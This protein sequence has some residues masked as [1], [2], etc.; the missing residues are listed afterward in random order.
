MQRFA[1]IIS[2]I[3][4]PLLMA[5]YGCLLL[6]FGIRHTIFDYMT[7]A[8]AKWRISVIV[9][10]FSFVFP[11]L[12]ILILYKLK[13]LPSITLSGQSDRTF[14]YIMT[15]MFYFGLFYLLKDV[16]IWQPVKLFVLGGGL[17]ILFVALINLK[18]KISAH[19]TGIGGLFG[20]LISLSC[21]IKFDMTLFYIL[22]I[23]VAGV[24]GMAR[25][26]LQE[27]KPG[28]LYSGFLLGLIVQS[29]LFFVYQKANFT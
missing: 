17:A 3:F 8:D 15:S 5:T 20:A 22:T 25:L 21:L 26:Y 1:R 12:N 28:Q 13:R 23:V 2:V 7:P 9:F 6:F 10:L 18:Y 29:G 24:I 16:N 19:M 11:V 4:H 14:P 27:H